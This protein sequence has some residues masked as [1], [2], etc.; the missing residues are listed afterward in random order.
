MRNGLPIDKVEAPRGGTTEHRM[1]D[2]QDFEACERGGLGHWLKIAS[3]ALEPPLPR[4]SADAPQY[5]RGERL[6]RRRTLAGVPGQLAQRPED[7]RPAGPGVAH[8][9][10]QARL[11]RR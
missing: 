6:V 9:R 11:V 2:L 1:R 5:L 10:R 4:E 8:R 3:R 7:L